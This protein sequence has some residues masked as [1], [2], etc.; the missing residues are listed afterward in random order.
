MAVITTD[1]ITQVPFSTPVAG[2]A[3]LVQNVTNYDG[4]T[5]NALTFKGMP[6]GDQNSDGTYQDPNGMLIQCLTNPTGDGGG[7]ATAAYASYDPAT[8]L[9]DQ[10]NPTQVTVNVYVKGAA[11]CTDL[12]VL[13]F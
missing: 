4:T 10:S 12:L 2:T 7:T 8:L 11:S 5:A 1:T 13:I 9:T 3:Y 6:I